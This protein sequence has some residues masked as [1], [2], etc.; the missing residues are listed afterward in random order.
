MDVI[1]SL[2]VSLGSSSVQL[3]DSLGSRHACACSE[4]GSVDKVATVLEGV[5][6]KSSVLLCVFCE[7]KDSVQIIFIKKC[8]LFKVGSVCR[9]K[10]FITGSRNSLMDIRKSQM[11]FTFYIRLWPIYWL[12]I[13]F[14]SNTLKFYDLEWKFCNRPGQNTGDSFWDLW[15]QAEGQ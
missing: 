11:M 7:Q 4:A 2:C 1:G 3:H 10:R 8:Y 9:V 6:P 14:N 12:S 13:V 15:S 5:L